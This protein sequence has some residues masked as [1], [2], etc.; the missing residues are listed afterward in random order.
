MSGAVSFKASLLDGVAPAAATHTSSGQMNADVHTASR[1]EAIS[2]SLTALFHK[3]V[4]SPG[5]HLGCRHVGS[6][7]SGPVTQTGNM[8]SSM[9]RISGKVGPC[10]SWFPESIS[11][12]A[13][14][15]LPCT[16][17]LQACSTTGL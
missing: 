7:A 9:Q 3:L 15:T 11:R 8:V 5:A 2:H 4:W 17:D 6:G 1:A 14:G 16:G 10:G 12:M 13:P